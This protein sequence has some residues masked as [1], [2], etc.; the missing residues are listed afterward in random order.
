MHILIVILT[1]ITE[2]IVTGVMELLF[3]SQNPP[4]LSDVV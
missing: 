4:Y 2:V 1:V 3:P